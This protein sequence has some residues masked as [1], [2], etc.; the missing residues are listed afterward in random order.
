MVQK[1]VP[2]IVG[3][4]DVIPHSIPWHVGIVR[5]GGTIPYCGGT[6]ISDRHVLTAAHCRISSYLPVEVLVAEHNLKSSVDGDR[7]SVCRFTNHP[8]Y[9]SKNVN[10]DYS[11]IHLS[12]PVK[13]SRKAVP[14]CLP[15]KW[16]SDGYLKSK[17]LTVSGWGKLSEKSE[18]RP[19]LLNYVVVPGI[20]HIDCVNYYGKLITQNMLCAGKPGGKED[21]CQN[22]SGGI[23]SSKF[24]IHE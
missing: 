23:V 1:D 13:P 12:H 4:S 21:A 6:L 3:G 17:N 22:D 7:R 24:N 16:M 19:N 20:S 18:E 5:K 14:A 2:R 15:P 8:N 10:F 11:I 9:D